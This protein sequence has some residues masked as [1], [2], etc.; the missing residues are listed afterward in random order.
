MPEKKMFA[1]EMIR[2][3][4]AWRNAPGMIFWSDPPLA[5]FLL[6]GNHVREDSVVLQQFFRTAFFSN[7]TT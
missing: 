4:S 3:W 1:Y 6:Q 7:M 5:A 2:E